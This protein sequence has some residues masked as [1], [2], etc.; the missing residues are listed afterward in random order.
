MNEEHKIGFLNLIRLADKGYQ[1]GYL[2]GALYEWV[3]DLFLKSNGRM[4]R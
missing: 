3:L 4:D 1:V 2:L